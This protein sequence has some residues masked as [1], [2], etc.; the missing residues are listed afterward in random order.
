MSI[1]VH[2]T[3][4]IYG[5]NLVHSWRT[6]IQETIEG[7][8]KR[9]SLV[10]WPTIKL[11]NRFNL[12]NT[13]ERRFIRAALYQNIHNIW[14]FPFIHDKTL[15]T[16]QAVG[17]QKVLSLAETSYRHFYDGRGCMLVS[18]YNWELYEYATIDTV[19]SVT[20]ITLK[21]N[22]LGTWSAGTC[23]YPMYEYRIE[24]VQEIDSYIKQLNY[25]TLTATETMEDLRSFSYSVP[26]SGASTYKGLDLFLE[27]PQHPIRI[28]YRHPFELLHFLGRSFACSFYDKA[29]PVFDSDFIFISRESI[30]NLLKFFDSKRGRF[31]VFYMPS[32]DNDIV[33]TAAI[34]AT[35][36]NLTVESLYL[37]SS[38]II[39]RHIWIRFVDGSYVCREV[40]AVP[41]V[42]TVT[43]DSAI[44]TDVP[45][46][47]I[48]KILVCYLNKVRFNIDEIL[49]EYIADSIV[50][51]KLRFQ[52]ISGEA[53]SPPPI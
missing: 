11:N 10:T 51:T 21:D 37:S 14:G 39:G 8:E 22:L 32:W 42:T 4:G 41:N 6:G 2:I 9:S 3:S 52:T 38:H 30:W 15:L 26:E 47:D 29:R 48:L 27:T 43:I 50:Q 7:H 44:G 23:V 46:S 53:E 20:Q 25:V 45:Q 33:P 36:T 5:Q 31:Q 16:N 13:R 28:K 12:V 1:S 35:D 49:L 19:D 17:G 40:V 24:D 34:L 18:H